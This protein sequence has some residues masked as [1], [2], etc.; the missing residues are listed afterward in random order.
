VAKVPVPS[1]TNSLSSGLDA[2]TVLGSTAPRLWTPP[3]RE[4]TPETSVGF[5]QIEFARDCAGTPV[6][7]RGRSGV[8]IHAGELLPD[9][10]PRFRKVLVMVARQNG[11]TEI[12]V[13]LSLYWQF[14]EAVPMILG[15]S[16]KLDYAKESWRRAV[17][18]GERAS[19]LD[20]LRPPR[21]KREANG[22]QESWTRED[23][24]YKIAAANANAGRSLTVDRLILDELRQHHDYTAWDAA[25]P[26]GNA[27]R[28]FQA[29]CM[30]NAGD[31]RSVVLNDLREAALTYI[32]TGE[33]D[34]TLC[35]LEWSAPED[36]DPLDLQA[37]AMANP[38]LGRR[39]DPRALLGDARKAVAKGGEVLTG[40]KTECMC[41]RVRQLDP[42]VD[43]GAWRAA[44]TPATWPPPGPGSRCAWTWRPTSSTRRSPPP[45]CCPMAARASR[46]CRRGRG[47]AAQTG[48]APTSPAPGARTAAGAGVVAQRPGGVAG[49]RSGG[50]EGPQGL[51]AAGA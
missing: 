42:A 19:K 35:L 29:W 38:N 3:L 48:C 12:P 8:V 7:R 5:H 31:D 23:A 32:E 4:L 44:S 50:P 14:V 17:Q 11:K 36:A 41:I 46:W 49:G 40:F 30:S 25:L 9:G 6:R 26:T 2:R 39:I 28:D 21:W 18:L 33:G 22:E 16:T 43:P 15:T 27:V 37:L 51:A 1:L 20:E 47:S 45:P 24:R 10:R 13:I 34:D